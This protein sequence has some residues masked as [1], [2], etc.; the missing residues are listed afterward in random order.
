M[1]MKLEFLV[2]GVE[3]TEEA[4][5][6]AEMSGVASDLQ[7]RF[8][9]GTKQQTI[10]HFFVLQSQRSQLWRQSEHDMD[11]GRG[12][13]FAAPCLDPAFASARLTLRAMAIAATVIRDG[14]TM[15]A[16]GALIDVTA[17][18]GGATARNREQDLDMGPADPRSVALNE[19]SSCTAN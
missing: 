10:D 9:T 13:Q 12:E 19:S 6:G 4:D 1:G 15:S 17:E 11:V 5:L 7:E 2:P 18:C 3:H 16:T 14:G 8:C